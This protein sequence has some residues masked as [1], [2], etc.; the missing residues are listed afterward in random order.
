MRRPIV[1]AALVFAAGGLLWAVAVIAEFGSVAGESTD[2]SQR[3]R[4]VDA[5]AGWDRQARWIDDHGPCRCGC[6]STLVP[7]GA[8][9]APHEIAATC[10]TRSSDLYKRSSRAAS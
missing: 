1:A 4:V 8:A 5:R 3:A 10:F 7:A 6:R 9:S 2:P